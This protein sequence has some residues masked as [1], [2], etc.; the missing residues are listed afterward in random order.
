MESNPTTPASTDTSSSAMQQQPPPL[1]L[2]E[3]P[4]GR[5]IS[6]VTLPQIPLPMDLG[7]SQQQHQPQQPHPILN[8][9]ATSSTPTSL[10]LNASMPSMG[11]HFPTQSSHLPTMTSVSPAPNPDSAAAAMAAAAAMGKLLQQGHHSGVQHHLG[12]A[13]GM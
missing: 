7:M 10:V 9:P 11:T 2:T 6:V 3:P 13:G 8:S 5:P 4:N 1:Q 12:N